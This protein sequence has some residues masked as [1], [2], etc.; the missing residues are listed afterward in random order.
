MG[1]FPLVMQHLH[2]TVDGA[3]G[4]CLFMEVLCEAGR[5]AVVVKGSSVF[6]VT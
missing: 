5:L 2:D 6:I 3:K 1:S 4:M